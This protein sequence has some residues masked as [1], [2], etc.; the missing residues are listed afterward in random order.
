MY[1]IPPKS[2]RP[3]NHYSVLAICLAVMLLLMYGVM[4]NISGKFA[5]VA[6][7]ND[8]VQTAKQPRPGVTPLAVATPTPATVDPAKTAVPTPATTDVTAKDLSTSPGAYR[9]RAIRVRGQVFYLGKTDDGK[10]W[11]QISDG[12]VYVNGAY[13]GALPQGVS[14]GADV[15]I[16]GI[17]AGLTTITSTFDGKDYDEPYIDPVQNIELSSGGSGSSASAP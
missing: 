10:Q 3:T 11:I 17:G 2:N 12:N 9:S 8:Q 13:P 16:T 6:A 15:F 1:P 5:E 14:K 4:R 7:G